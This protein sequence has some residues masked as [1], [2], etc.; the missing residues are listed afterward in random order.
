[1]ALGFSKESDNVWSMSLNTD[2]FK[3]DLKEEKIR[4]P[5][6]IKI[7]RNTITN[8]EAEENFVVLNAT[9]N[10]VRQG[11][12]SENIEIEKG[13]RLSLNTKSGNADI[14]VNDYD[15]KTFMI[16]ECKTY[17]TEFDKAWKDTLK[18]GGKY[19]L[20]KSKRTH[21]E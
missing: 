4:Y 3:I 2:I 21:Q 15:K 6:F 9:I 16:I 20:M 19:F 5:K 7:G 14:T 8:F 17:G 11:Y 1:M 10:L 12:A 13:Y 18:D